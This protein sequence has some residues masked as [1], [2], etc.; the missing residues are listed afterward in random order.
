[1]ERAIARAR[2][3]DFTD[4]TERTTEADLRRGRVARRVERRAVLR[5]ALAAIGNSSP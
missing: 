2:T 1:V 5:A 4:F 3:A